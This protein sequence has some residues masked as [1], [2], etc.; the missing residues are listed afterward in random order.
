MLALRKAVPSYDG[1]VSYGVFRQDFD[2]DDLVSAYPGL[3]D[4]QRFTL[5]TSALY[6]DPKSMVTCTFKLL[7]SAST[8]SSHWLSLISSSHCRGLCWC[9]FVRNCVEVSDFTLDF[10]YIDDETTSQTR[11]RNPLEEERCAND[12]DPSCSNNNTLYEIHLGTD[13]VICLDKKELD[14]ILKKC[15]N[16]EKDDT[17]IDTDSDDDEKKSDTKKGSG[18]ENSQDET[19]V[20]KL[21]TKVMMIKIQMNR[22]RVPKGKRQMKTQ[23]LTRGQKEIVPNEGDRPKMMIPMMM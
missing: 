23:K 6:K 11:L 17:S 22:R 12:D 21:L 7:S 19:D 15:E 1:R 10:V 13:V 2:D 14:S 3:T 9:C 20:Q 16:N 18:T 5:L 8:S 4:R